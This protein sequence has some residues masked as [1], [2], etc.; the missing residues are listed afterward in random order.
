MLGFCVD[1]K[2]EAEYRNQV[3]KNT[4]ILCY[5]SIYQRL[6]GKSML[7]CQRAA[8]HVL[9][10]LGERVRNEIVLQARAGLQVYG[11]SSECSQGNWNSL[12]A[13]ERRKKR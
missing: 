1:D 5:L 10:E 8:A 11:G 2:R 12:L 7:G 6:R 13:R 9:R 4:S 3:T